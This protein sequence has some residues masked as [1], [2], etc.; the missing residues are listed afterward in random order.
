MHP[1]VWPAGHYTQEFKLAAASQR[2]YCKTNESN[3]VFEQQLN[4]C[5]CEIL[6]IWTRSL[7]EQSA[8]HLEH[9]A[10]LMLRRVRE[11]KP[12]RGSSSSRQLVSKSVSSKLAS[13]GRYAAYCNTLQGTCKSL[14]KTASETG[15]SQVLAARKICACSWPT[16]LR[17][18]DV[19]QTWGHG[20][21]VMLPLKAELELSQLGVAGDELK[22][23]IWQ[24]STA[25]QAQGT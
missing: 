21:Q 19:R 13:L 14:S 15:P 22:R 1:T 23:S 5:H 24:L 20:L 17:Y 7:C 6:H 8:A 18:P 11:L 10:W 25:A 12:D 4:L 16:M 3:V 9:L 2:I